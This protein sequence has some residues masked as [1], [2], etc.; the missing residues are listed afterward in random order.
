LTPE[1][2]FEL[3]ESVNFENLV[4]V[5]AQGEALIDEQ[6][7]TV[8]NLNT[9]QEHTS[10]AIALLIA[11]FRYSHLQGKSILFVNVP[12]ELRNIIELAELDDLLPL[13]GDGKNSS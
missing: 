10:A 12:V 9:L 5:R 13:E 7:A 1:N 4:R 8:F 6:D 11:W 3:P 2:G